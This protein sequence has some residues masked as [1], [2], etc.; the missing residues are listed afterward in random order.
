MLSDKASAELF[1]NTTKSI[2]HLFPVRYLKCKSKRQ[3]LTVRTVLNQHGNGI[4]ALPEDVGS[5][6]VSGVPH[7][8]PADFQQLVADL[9]AHPAGQ[10]VFVD[11]RN[12]DAAALRTVDLDAQRL[13]G[14]VNVDSPEFTGQRFL[15]PAVVW[16]TA[17]LVAVTR[18]QNLNLKNYHKLQ[19]NKQ[20]DKF[21]IQC[22]IVSRVK[23]AKNKKVF[24]HF[25]L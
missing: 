10:T 4:P 18:T 1:S 23:H 16:Y 11:R 6:I 19:K 9:E 20:V 7:V 15:R 2:I 12:E 17:A 22:K 13:V 25:I 21:V 24:D 3:I 8:D 14:L 5:Q